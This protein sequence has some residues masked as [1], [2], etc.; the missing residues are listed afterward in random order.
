MSQLLQVLGALLLLSG[1]IAA[2]AGA[3][4]D[5]SLRYLLVNAVGGALL[6]AIAYADRDYGF[7]LLEGTWAAVST[8]S[9]CRAYHARA[10]SAHDTEPSWVFPAGKHSEGANWPLPVSRTIGLSGD[11]LSTE[12][13][14]IRLFR[15]SYA[16]AQGRQWLQ[17]HVLWWILA[18]LRDNGIRIDFET[19]TTT[20]LRVKTT[21]M[22][23]P[24][25]HSEVHPGDQAELNFALWWSL[26]I[27]I[28]KVVYRPRRHRILPGGGNGLPTLAELHER[29]WQ[30]G[31]RPWMSSATFE[32]LAGI[33]QAL[34]TI[35]RHERIR[36]A[37][38]DRIMT[39]VL[40]PELLLA[41]LHWLHTPGGRTRSASKPRIDVALLRRHSKAQLR[42]NDERYLE[43]LDHMYLRAGDILDHLVRQPERSRTPALDSLLGMYEELLL[44]DVDGTEHLD[45]VPNSPD[46]VETVSAA[47]ASRRN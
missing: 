47:S 38:P 44:A 32:E 18:F 29:A 7:L 43:P 35:D 45:D 15:N 39:G 5:T 12:L 33:A 10:N 37:D 24:A 40:L 34:E 17:P 13:R 1:F 30:L 46:N 3:L 27:D 20:G 11:E 36:P 6:A 19:L 42:W 25:G 22:P 28:A 23:L 14:I 16:G 8:L 41:E 9:L 4:R 26:F 21:T 31:L 2:Q